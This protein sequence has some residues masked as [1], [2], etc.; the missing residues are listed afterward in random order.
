[1]NF[2]IRQHSN[3]PVLKVQLFKDSRNNFREFANDLLDATITFSMADEITGTYVI[4]DQPAY[5]EENVGYP[6]EYFIVYQFTKKQTKK[7][8]GYIGQFKVKN[9]QGEIIVPVREILQINITDSF[10]IG[11]ASASSS[12]CKVNG[13]FVPT[14]R[15]SETPNPLFVS[16]TPT[17]TVTPSTTTTNTP[18]QTLTPTHTPTPSP[19][20]PIYDFSLRYSSSSFTDACLQPIDGVEYYSNTPPPLMPN[21]VLYFNDGTGSQIAP[22]GYYV[23]EDYSIGYRMGSTPNQFILEVD[24]D[25]CTPDPSLTPTNTPTPTLT[26]TPTPTPS[27]TNTPTQT[28]SS[29][30]DQTSTP[31]QTKTPTQT[32][33]QTSTPTFTPTQ[34]KTPTQTPTQTPSSSQPPQPYLGGIRLYYDP[35]QT[36]SYPGSGPTVF[37]LSGEGNDGTLSGVTFTNPYFQLD[38]FGSQIIIP[39]NSSLEPGSSDWTVEVWI[40]PSVLNNTSDVIIGKFDNGGGSQDVSYA[41]R[42]NNTNRV[43]FNIGN[44]VTAIQTSSYPLSTNT[45]YQIVGMYAGGFPRLY[46]NAADVGA[47]LSTIASILNTTNQ[48]YIGSYN[49]G[50]YSQLFN[51]K[52][53]IV[54]IYQGALNQLLLLQNFNVDKSKYG[55]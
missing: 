5:L 33:T 36:A 28:P 6:G 23:T 7:T 3:L 2:F 54:R 22:E 43:Y 44:G 1:M 48:L 21:D 17:N 51:G 20:T 10:K 16:P 15:P 31:T 47:S 27:I 12:C 35:S 11:D 40:N 39:D 49:G 19:S 26:Q 52:V 25:P 45:W 38:G 46:V 55:L 4:V 41:L 18:T 53:G 24:V 42:I 37:D 13:G 32:P 29:T 34:T 30:P 8:G 9:N 14:P 50:E